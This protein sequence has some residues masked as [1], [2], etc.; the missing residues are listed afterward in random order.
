[1]GRRDLSLAC[2]EPAFGPW[3][4]KQPQT[5]QSPILVI[6]ALWRRNQKFKVVLSNTGNSG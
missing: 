3:H 5:R 6:S 2:M 4:L 1:M